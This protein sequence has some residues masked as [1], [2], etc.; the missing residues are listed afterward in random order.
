MLGDDEN[1]DVAPEVEVAAGHG[2][3][4]HHGENAQGW[5]QAGGEAPSPG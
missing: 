5:V 3:V 1:V 2:A 4:D